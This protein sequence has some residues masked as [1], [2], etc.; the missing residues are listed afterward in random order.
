MDKRQT[1]RWLKA[2]EIAENLFEDEGY[3]SNYLEEIKD[4]ILTS[5]EGLSEPEGKGDAHAS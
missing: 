1:R 3:S 5:R 4:F 2:L